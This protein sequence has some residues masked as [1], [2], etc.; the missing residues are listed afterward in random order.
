MSVDD[1]C[2]DFGRVYISE[3]KY[4]TDPEDYGWTFQG[5]RGGRSG[6]E[7]YT[8]VML[9]SGCE[10]EQEVKLILWPTTGAAWA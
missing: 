3:R 2:S 10:E 7:H 4:T 5:H 1:L 8:R 6:A 9:L